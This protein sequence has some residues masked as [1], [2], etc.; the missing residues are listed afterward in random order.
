M[1]DDHLPQSIWSGSF[2]LFGVEIECH[3]LDDGQRII[4]AES[5]ERL[6]EAMARVDDRKAPEPDEMDS[7]GRWLQGLD[8]GPTS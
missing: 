7:F 3:I 5:I 2:T 6:F 1:S 4:E 8:K